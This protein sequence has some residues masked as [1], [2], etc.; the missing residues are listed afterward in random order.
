LK[1][2]ANFK[3][4]VQCFEIFGGTNTSPLVARL[5]FSISDEQATYKL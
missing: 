3:I 5:V 4:A 1:F 2:S